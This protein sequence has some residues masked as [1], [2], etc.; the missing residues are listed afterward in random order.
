MTNLIER[1]RRLDLRLIAPGGVAGNWPN[2]TIDAIRRFRAQVYHERASLPLASDASA[3]DVDERG[4]HLVVRR[5]TQLIGCVRFVFFHRRDA[6]DVPERLLVNSRC[7]FSATDRVRCLAA[8]A[9][10]AREWRR[11]GGPLGQAGGLAV[12]AHARTSVVAPALC[13]AG[14]ALGRL[15]GAA[16][17][18]VFADEKSA[19]LYARAGCSPLLS[20]QLPLGFLVD[21]FHRDRVLVMR[22][23]P[24]GLVTELE[25][26]VI[27][28][29]GL[30]EA[31]MTRPR[32]GCSHAYAGFEAHGRFG[33][34]VDLNHRMEGPVLEIACVKEP[35]P[36]DEP[37]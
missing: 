7:K 24:L 21:S 25:E 20:G 4:W 28:L 6:D 17:G 19:N 30:L 37:H 10:Y 15:L 23:D 33:A 34:R 11:V 8:L 13:L 27:E 29:R 3:D 1:I 14:I 36:N 31:A 9:E 35:G 5:D 16:R 2:P 32:T 26:T 12:A 18:I 22:I